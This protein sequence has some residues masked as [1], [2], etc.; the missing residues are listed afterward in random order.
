MSTQKQ[1]VE[2]F[3]QIND[4][5]LNQIG[6]DGRYN[7]DR[8]FAAAGVPV[9]KSTGNYGGK[10]FGLNDKQRKAVKAAMERELGFQFP[11]GIEIDSAGNMNE[12]EGF[13]KQLKKYGVPAGQIALGMLTGGMSLPA[14]LALNAAAGAGLGAMDGGWEGALKG[15][16]MGAASAYGG[17]LLSGSGAAA[18]SAAKGGTTA[19][20]GKV[21]V[22]GFLL[23]LGKDIGKDIGKDFAAQGAD[24]LLDAASGGLSGASRTMTANRSNEANMLMSKMAVQERMMNDRDQAQ[25][26]N[27]GDAW[28]RL[29]QAN[30]L[31]SGG[32]Q[33]PGV[34][35]AYSRPAPKVSPDSMKMASD[36]NLQSAL[37]SR[38]TYQ[39]DPFAGMDTSF[40]A[41]DKTAKPGFME[42]MLGYG[43]LATGAL[44]KLDIFGGGQPKPKPVTQIS[45]DPSRWDLENY[46]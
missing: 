44:G 38:A 7:R 36:P 9:A 43:G 15:G 46:G 26:L 10:D 32:M 2:M 33:S 1:N 14:Q 11:K 12:N 3:R 5:Y 29:L 42:Q 30:Y 17:H 4:G 21:G 25:R 37:M 40:T 8:L 39:H 6:P 19:G 22:G 20:A 16:A 13:G 23:N 34:A 28:K 45:D 35:G 24:K 31:K 41:L 27:A 18:S